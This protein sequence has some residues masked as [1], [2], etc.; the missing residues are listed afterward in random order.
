MV[1]TRKGPYVEKSF[2]RYMRCHCSHCFRRYPERFTKTWFRTQPYTSKNGYIRIS[3]LVNYQQS[4]AEQRLRQDSYCTKAPWN[5]PRNINIAYSKKYDIGKGLKMTKSAG[6]IL[7][8]FDDSIN[9]FSD[10]IGQSTADIG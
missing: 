1:L 7:N 3:Q 2:D 9:P 6:T 4:V 8:D 5:L 10:C